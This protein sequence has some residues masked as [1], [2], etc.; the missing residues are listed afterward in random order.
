ML[1]A[2]LS[3]RGEQFCPCKESSA[4]FLGRQ[5]YSPKRTLN[6]DRRRSAEMRCGEKYQLIYMPPLGLMVWPV[7]KE[8][9][10]SITAMRPTSSTEPVVP[11]GMR[12]A[13]SLGKPAIISVSIRAGAMALAVMPSLA[14]CEAYERVRPKTPALEAA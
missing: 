13:M 9:W 8:L 11:T 4:R 6:L 12:V 7:M 14:N 2:A 3:L 10:A 1:A 5:F